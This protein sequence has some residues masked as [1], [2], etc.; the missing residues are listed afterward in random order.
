MSGRKFV[1]VDGAARTG[2]GRY[3]KNKTDDS[4]KDS[5]EITK[6]GHVSFEMTRTP[7]NRRLARLT[8]RLMLS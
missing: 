5:G 4:T 7:P 6:Y 1:V 8:V 3:P 2:C